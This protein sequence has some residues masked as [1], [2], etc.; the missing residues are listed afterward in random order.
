M[1]TYS[2]AIKTT[3]TITGTCGT[4]CVTIHKRMVVFILPKY[5]AGVCSGHEIKFNAFLHLLLGADEW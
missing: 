3:E 2:S 1:Q 5:H 4:L